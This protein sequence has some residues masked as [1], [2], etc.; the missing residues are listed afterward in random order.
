MP[1]FIYKN[2]A[3]TLLG[4]HY[5]KIKL[6]GKDQ[7]TLAYGSQL[8]LFCKG[9]MQYLEH[10]PI[11]GFESSMEP[12]SIFGLGDQTL[13][14]SVQVIFPDGSF[15]KTNQVKADQT[16]HLDQ[17]N[18]SPGHYP[19]Q[20]TPDPLLRQMNIPDVRH[21]E[22][23]YSDFDRD[24]LLYHMISNEGPKLSIGDINGDGL[25]D[26]YLGQAKGTAK[27]VLIQ[28]S[29]G[30]F[31][32]TFPKSFNAAIQSEDIGSA[33]V[34][35]DHDGD[36]DLYVCSGSNEDAEVS[37]N[38]MDRLYINDLKGNFTL[39]PQILPTFKFESTSCVR[40]CDI[41][42]DGDMDLFVGVRQKPFYY[43]VPVNGYILINDGK[44]NYSNQT[45][46]LAPGLINSGMIT[47]AVWADFN[48]D[49]ILD[50]AICGE[51]MPVKVF[52]N[53]NGHLQQ[54]PQAIPN[55]WWNT[56]Y[57][58]D[59]DQDGDIDIIAGNHGLNSRFKATSSQPIRMY[60]NDFDHNGTVEQLI[61]SYR[62]GKEYPFSLKHDLISQ[63]PVLKK[64]YLRYAAFAGQQVM[65]FFPEVS[66]SS[67]LIDSVS[68]L[69]TCLFMNDS[70]GHF[71][72]KP[73]PIEAQFSPVYAIY[74]DDFNKD[75]LPDI[76]IGGNQYRTKPETGRYDASYGLV[77]LQTKAHEFIS[78][79]GSVSG[80]HVMGEIRDIKPILIKGKKQIII[81]RNNDTPLIYSIQ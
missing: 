9:Q 78:L 29:N 22:D 13:V 80:I 79:P 46:A 59:I 15:I 64:K 56:M 6:T 27:S 73:L 54:A 42:G 20:K 41:D 66:Q 51:Y 48:G 58:T 76:L 52:F 57:A 55:G 2:Q 7:N 38:L 63:M 1:C 4:H 43:G 62:D 50:L 35:V 75:G 47:D 23:D 81:A 44:G 60:V 31:Q 16:L 33:L 28:K 17:S 5:L 39:S 69:Q 53:M 70:K 67:T 14:D 18:A 72:I 19:E 71:T 74:S 3:T 21:V 34:D 26:I 77:M 68:Y 40:P 32:H 12:V 10:M 11:R 45:Q 65:D 30:T 49:K 37:T 25:D 24:R 61:T 36:L 8:K